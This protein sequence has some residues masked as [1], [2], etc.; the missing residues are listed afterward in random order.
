MI[1]PKLMTSKINEYIVYLLS[2]Y[3]GISFSL[4]A[5]SYH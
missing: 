1:S 3:V 2:G 5:E 4:V